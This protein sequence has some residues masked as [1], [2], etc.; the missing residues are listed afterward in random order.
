MTAACSA[1]RRE[2]FF[3]V[4][5]FTELLPLNFND[6]DLCYKTRKE[7]YRIVWVANSEAYHFESRTRVNTVESWEKDFAV[8]RWGWPR[9]DRYLP[10]VAPDRVRKYKR[11]GK[12][13]TKPR[14]TSR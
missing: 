5:G 8:R 4:G 6:V 12:G 3:E 7:G 2:V 10:G 9:D 11:Q 13:A 1:M 14:S